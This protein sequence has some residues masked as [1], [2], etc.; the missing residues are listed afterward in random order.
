MALEVARRSVVLLRNDGVLPL[1]ATTARVALIGPNAD[2]FGAVFGCYSFVNHV[3]P[4]HPSVEPGIAAPTVAASLAELLP[5]AAVTVTTGCAVTGD[6]RTGIPAAVQAASEAEVAVVVVGDAS[7]M[8]GQGTSGEGCDVT[9]LR[10]P[11]VQSELVAAVLASGTPTVLVLLSGRPYELGAFAGR[12]AAV[13]QAFLPGQEGGRAVAEV[14]TGR[15]NPS[16][17][18]PVG[19]PG[20]ASPQPSGYLAPRLGARTAMSSADPTPSHPFG[21]GLSYTTFERTALR[22]VTPSVS[23]AD[24]QDAGAVVVLETSV[25]NTGAVAGADVLQVYLHDPVAQV[26]VPERRLVAFLRVPLAAGE[27]QGW[28]VTIPVG[29]FAFAGR[30]GTRILEPGRVELILAAD[31]ADEGS[32]VA[33]ELVGAV[34][35]VPRLAD[36]PVWTRSGTVSTSPTP[37]G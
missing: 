1:A 26:A 17:R 15:V 2:R 5:D 35:A 10:L 9:D 29:A 4:R 36:P 22:T 14:L 33:V 23:L 19:L 20:E 8:F 25:R 18:L 12:C 7:G 28:R 21:F 32:R 34:R 37:G 30:D 3:L 24:G 16:G 6:D 11:G 31:A 27:E 13:V